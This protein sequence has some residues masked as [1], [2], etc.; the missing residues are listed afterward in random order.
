MSTLGSE[1]LQSARQRV[2]EPFRH[3]FKPVNLCESGRT[4]TDACMERG[5]DPTGYDCSGL[6]I[7]SL[8]EVLKLSTSRWPRELRHTQQLAQLAADVEPQPGD[9]RLYYSS[10]GRIHI[11][12]ATEKQAAVHASGLTKR[13]EE[14]IVTDP[15]G[16]FEAVRAIAID[17]LYKIIT[18]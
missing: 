8:C 14:S 3:H 6:A 11:G 12:I 17:S 9:L 7:A 18:R 4:T 2:N 1:V 10:N 15:S 16:S 13:V 5:M